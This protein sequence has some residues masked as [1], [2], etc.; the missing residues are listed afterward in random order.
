MKTFIPE[1][2]T[3]LAILALLVI[4]LGA[5]VRPP[6][7]DRTGGW[8]VRVHYRESFH[9]R[10]LRSRLASWLTEG[11]NEAYLAEGERYGIGNK[12]KGLITNDIYVFTKRKEPRFNVVLNVED[13]CIRARLRE[14][15]EIGVSTSASP[16]HKK[17]EII[18]R[19]N[20]TLLLD[21]VALEIEKTAGGDESSVIG[22]L[23]E[24][25]TRTGKLFSRNRIYL[26][27][28]FSAALA[29]WTMVSVQGVTLQFRWT[30]L[31]CVLL[32]LVF[33]TLVW[34]MDKN[35]RAIRRLVGIMVVFMNLGLSVMYRIFPV[36]HRM[37]PLHQES[38]MDG[39]V[40]TI[41]VI[42]GFAAA[43]FGTRLLVNRN[44]AWKA[45]VFAASFA[46][47]PIILVL[48]RFWPPV[49]GAH[50]QFWRILIFP[51]VL[52]FYPFVVAILTS[53]REDKE[54]ITIRKK[55]YKT[56][57]VPLIILLVYT[58]ILMLLSAGD[59]EFSLIVV[60]GVSLMV[61]FFV[62]CVGAFYKTLFISLGVVGSLAAVAMVD[63]IQ[64]R[65][66]VWLDP[67]SLNGTSLAETVLYLF[68]N[69]Y[70]MGWWGK[71]I[72]DL[73][74]AYY[75]TLAEDHAL[76]TLFND[77][78]V[79]IA[80]AVIVLGMLMFK[81]MLTVPD[82]LGPYDRYL[83]MTSGL[84]IG[85]I[86]VLNVASCLGSFITAGIGFPWIS[87]GAQCNI[88]L[89]I[90]VGI[91]CGIVHKKLEAEHVKSQ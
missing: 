36:A 68:R 20:E 49:N 91:H 43:Y 14:G 71:G 4:E 9:N 13:D 84:I 18:I 63:R 37:N 57:T 60:L 7:N 80:L 76:V 52:V 21:T 54:E 62:R 69:F 89:S 31:F 64:Y 8:R 88:M 6:R 47:P 17:D 65:A 3:V 33:L 86:I 53:L 46:I 42:A 27:Y 19:R 73:P 25:S 40:A 87:H 75:T 28:V 72:G 51:A 39:L 35:W 26:Y 61:I 81:W 10:S 83:N 85:S 12:L 66:M 67:A 70:S 5:N 24:D 90:L 78:S 41:G 32:S 48:A 23:T 16:V 22:K 82:G 59:N 55:E 15:K 2:I 79:F 34:I 56:P 29:I 74:V 11:E 58:F 45:L 30:Y 1:L 50:I 38:F 77:Y 44:R